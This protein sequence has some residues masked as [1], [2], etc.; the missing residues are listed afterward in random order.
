M[1]LFIE[2]TWIVWWL[3][4]VLASLRWFY[5]SDVES[6]AELEDACDDPDYSGPALTLPEEAPL[7]K[8]LFLAGTY[9]MLSEGIQPVG[10]G[11]KRSPRSDVASLFISEMLSDKELRG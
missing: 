8:T 7:P 11:S 2:R 3:L 6:P 4:I 1:L 5:A 10:F 9:Q